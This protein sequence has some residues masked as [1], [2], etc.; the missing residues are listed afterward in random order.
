M[1]VFHFIYRLL[2]QLPDVMSCHTTRW[3]P[4]LFPLTVH[5]AHKI[6]EKAHQAI[7]LAMPSLRKHQSELAPSL[8]SSLKSTMLVDMAELFSN[9]QERYV[10]QMWKLCVELLEKVGHLCQRNEGQFIELISH[11]YRDAVSEKKGEETLL[12]SIVMNFS[13]SNHF[14]LVLFSGASQR[15]KSHQSDAKNCWARIQ[16]WLPRD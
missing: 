8:V 5:S 6:R 15:W 2:E 3:A 7:Q 16:T 11:I 12:Y 9:K 10:L 13:F 14:G 1:F 4:L